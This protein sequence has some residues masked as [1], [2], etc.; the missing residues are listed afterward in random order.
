MY[1]MLCNT[2]AEE[3][4]LIAKIAVGKAFLSVTRS[5]GK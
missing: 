2:V 3:Q 1:E 5:V 4:P